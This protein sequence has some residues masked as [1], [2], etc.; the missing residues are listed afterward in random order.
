MILFNFLKGS[1][2]FTSLPPTPYTVP[3]ATSAPI[4]YTIRSSLP[5]AEDSRPS[6]RPPP[7]SRWTSR[8]MRWSCHTGCCRSVER[9][10]AICRTT[11]WT[12]RQRSR[13]R[14]RPRGHKQCRVDSSAGGPRSIRPGGVAAN[15]LWYLNN[16]YTQRPLCHT[17]AHLNDGTLGSG[18]QAHP[19]STNPQQ[20]LPSAHATE[21]LQGRT[22]T[23]RET[24][25]IIYYIIKHYF[26][27]MIYIY[28]Y[29]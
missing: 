13:R 14:W 26:K 20:V 6:R 25:I 3:C 2:V 8:D 4:R 18:Q 28:I 10:R 5:E 29:P 9:R 12:C 22:L 16:I 19:S 24:I 23:E 15:K 11:A 7:C 27:K 17:H 21:S 1:E